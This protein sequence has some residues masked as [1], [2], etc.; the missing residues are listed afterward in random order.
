MKSSIAYVSF[1]NIYASIPG[2]F[3]MIMIIFFQEP[4]NFKRVM[5]LASTVG[6]FTPGDCAEIKV[7]SAAVYY[8]Y[9]HIVI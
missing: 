3:F 9:E 5:A 8:L 1:N 7:R 6:V 2:V 4:S